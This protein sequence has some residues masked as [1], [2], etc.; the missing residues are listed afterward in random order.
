MAIDLVRRRFSTE[1]YHR[2][3]QAGIFGE[4]DRVELLGGDVV[5]MSPIGSAH[6]ACVNRL[7]SWFARRLRERAQ[8]SVQNP[9]RL[10]DRS[11]PQPDVVLLRPRADFYES[12]LPGPADV[13]LLVEVV[14]TTAEA[15]RGFKLPLYSHSGIVEVWIVD[16]AAGVIEVHR[17]PDGVGYRESVRTGRGQAVAAGAFPDQPILVVDAIG[18]ALA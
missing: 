2:M 7:N 11:E 10:D 4:D 1:E 8:V 16:L 12:A 15:D 14:D 6:V 13:L 17:Q 5:R 18:P 9:I 3:A